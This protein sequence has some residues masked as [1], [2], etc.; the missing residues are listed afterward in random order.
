[1]K[2][3]NLLGEE[4][5]VEVLTFELKPPHLNIFRDGKFIAYAD[6]VPNKSYELGQPSIY[7]FSG[8]ETFSLTELQ[9]IIVEMV[10]AWYL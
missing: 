1:M 9:Q 5:E 6:A 3:K 2:K 4:V 10:R 7:I 8:N